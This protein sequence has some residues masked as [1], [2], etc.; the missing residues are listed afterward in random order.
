MSNATDLLPPIPSDI[1]ATTG[2][3]II[4]TLIN[5]A[6]YGVLSVQTY[7]YY[8]NFPD[9]NIWNKLL[10]YGSYIVEVVQ[11]AMTAA[12]LC[13][14]FASGFGNMNHLGNVNIS[15]VDT[16]I[17][18]G[19]IA[20]VVQCF[21]AYRIYNLRRSL[22]WVS[23]LIVLT[24]IV[25]TVGAFGVGY[26]AFKLQEYVDFHENVIFPQSFDVCYSFYLEIEV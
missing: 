14:W 5:W 23:V 26:R 13:F 12:D 4:G 15:P 3:Q 21:F 18:C 7:V 11:T 20:A 10:V 16:P 9:D 17:L 6:L 1:A 2:P 25:Q 22:L 8:L 24:S 19:I